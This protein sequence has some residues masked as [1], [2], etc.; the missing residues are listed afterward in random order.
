MA[1]S[2]TQTPERPQEHPVA[3]VLRSRGFVPL[4]R[5][6]VRSKDM[7]TIHMIAGQYR[8]EVN[9]VRAEVGAQAQAHAQTTQ[10]APPTNRGVNPKPDPKTDKDAT[11]S[12]HLA[13][14]ITD[15]FYDAF[16][17]APDGK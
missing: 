7:P 2:D 15:E 17:G 12:A 6:W 1:K 9:A 4:P 11:C 8:E 5:L 3:T 14:R 13:S 16:K 10:D